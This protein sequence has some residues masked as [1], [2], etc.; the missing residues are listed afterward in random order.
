LADLKNPPPVYR[1]RLE[2]EEEEKK[3]V[4]REGGG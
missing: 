1:L 3:K 4:D 2:E